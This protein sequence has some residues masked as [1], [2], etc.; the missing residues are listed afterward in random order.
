M[1]DGNVCQMRNLWARHAKSLK[2]W[3]VINPGTVS[4][5]DMTHDL[6]G[7]SVTYRVYKLI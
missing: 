2:P 5:S 7:M 6:L 4:E 3:D 1:S